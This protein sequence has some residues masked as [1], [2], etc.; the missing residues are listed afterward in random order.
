M[1]AL[2]VG[3]RDKELTALHRSAGTV[4]LLAVSGFHVGIIVSFFSLFFRRGK[5]KL[6]PLSLL[7]WFYIVLAGLPPGGIRAALMVQIYLLGL[8]AGKPSSSFNSVSTAGIILLLFNPW[9]FYDVGWRLSMLA[10]QP[11]LSPRS[12]KAWLWRRKP[13]SMPACFKASLRGWR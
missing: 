11:A 13:A 6:L 12:F 9:T 8:W 10:A 4:H 1:L 5:L 7:M 3:V 2:T